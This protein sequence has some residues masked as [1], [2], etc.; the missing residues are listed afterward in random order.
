MA[1]PSIKCEICGAHLEAD[2]EH[3]LAETFQEHAKHEH[4]MDMDHG[5]AMKKVRMAQ[6]GDA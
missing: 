6:E 3:E 2:T 4:D 1:K 5:M